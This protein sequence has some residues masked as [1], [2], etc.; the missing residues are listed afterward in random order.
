MLQHIIYATRE[1]FENMVQFGAYFDQ[2]VS[3]KINI[4]LYKK[5]I[6]V[7]TIML[8]GF[9]GIFTMNKHEI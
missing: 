8:M 5:N 1:N 3:W 7:A 6:I 2:I 9:Q 4:F